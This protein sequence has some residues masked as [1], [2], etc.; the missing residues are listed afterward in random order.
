M[1]QAKRD[2]TERPFDLDAYLIS[3]IVLVSRKNVLEKK[4]NFQISN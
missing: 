1:E 3:K 2:M 4:R